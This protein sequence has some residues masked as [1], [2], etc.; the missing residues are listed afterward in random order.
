MNTK[1]IPISAAK[2]IAKKYGY[3]QVVIFAR[4]VGEEGREH[5]T[6]YGVDKVHC[7][8]AAR[9]GNFLKYK[10]MGWIKEDEKE[11]NL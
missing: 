11:D 1:P 8:V 5:M 6:T 7:D 10:I 4:K 2:E 3:D 9:I